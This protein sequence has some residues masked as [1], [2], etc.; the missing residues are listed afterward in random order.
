MKK[1]LI[2]LA[3]I[4]VSGTAF[5]QST[6]T[7][8]GKF[9]TAQQKA[10]GGVAGLAVTDGDVRFTAVEDLGGGLK[11]NASMEIAIR[12]RTAAAPNHYRNSTVGL[13]GG[14][15]SV[16][17]GAVEAGNGIV[18]LGFAG[19]PVS[20]ASGYDGAV[21]SGA[22]NVD[23]AA[24]TTPA[25]IP[26]LTA[27]LMRVDSITAPG[28]GKSINANVIGVNY[29][30][31]AL[32]AALDSTTYSTDKTRIRASASYDLGVATVGVGFEDNKKAADTEG[33]QLA[34][35]VRV[36]MGAITLGFIYASSDENTTNKK[37]TGWGVGADYAFSKRTT[38]NVSY[39]DRTKL[40][41]ATDDNGDQ[42]RIRL[43]HA[44]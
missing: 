29:K 8:S 31:G 20:L 22:G 41:G 16:T 10:I 12:G 27:T 30:A 40:A 18:G 11:A 23:L 38:L 5:A 32:T 9:A 4:A 24:Y 6:V 39:G 25:L 3:V 2:A 17:L 34:M 13:S 35:G 43:T 33:T 28:A 14:F 44:F 19:A 21:L 1:S 36:P 42:Y 26:G 15:G 37:T 7:L